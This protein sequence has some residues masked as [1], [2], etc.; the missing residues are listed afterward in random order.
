LDSFTGKVKNA[1]HVNN[2]TFLV[3]FFS[4]KQA[5]AILVQMF[6]DPTLSIPFHVERQVFLNSSW[7]VITTHPLGSVSDEE[8]VEATLDNRFMSKAYTLIRK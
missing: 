8:I 5:E 7:G 2:G 1:S 6:L 4:N 3:E